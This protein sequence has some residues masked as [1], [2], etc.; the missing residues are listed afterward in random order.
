MS[1]CVWG[2]GWFLQAVEIAAAD[3]KLK[4]ASKLAD[5]EDKIHE[6]EQN[7]QHLENAQSAGHDAGTEPPSP[8]VSSAWSMSQQSELHSLRQQIVRL[9]NENAQLKSQSDESVD[10]LEVDNKQHLVDHLE[11]QQADLL[12]ENRQL[13]RRVATLEQGAGAPS[14]PQPDRSEARAQ[15]KEAIGTYK[16][17]LSAKQ[18]DLEKLTTEKMKMEAYFQNVMNNMT[19]QKGKFKVAMQSLREQVQTQ[20]ATISGLQ[21]AHKREQQLFQSAFYNMGRELA[22]GLLQEAAANR[23]RTPG[24]SSS[25]Q[26]T[27]TSGAGTSWLGRKRMELKR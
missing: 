19:K 18:K 11:K 6:L 26:G 23:L 8:A 25:A 13:K 16:A 3:Y 9:K 14:T 22:P 10:T 17:Q 5:A 12:K 27:P 15:L 21:L 4:S 7:L 2:I 1:V 24:R 20:Q